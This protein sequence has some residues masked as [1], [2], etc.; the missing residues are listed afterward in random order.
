M[1]F[2]IIKY[3]VALI[4]SFSFILAQSSRMGTASS[5]QLQIAQGAQYLSGGG[6]AS[7][8][9]GMGAVYWNPAGLSK[10]E[11][12]FDAIFS[13]R[14]YI[15]DITNNYF[16]VGGNFGNLGKLALTV[17]TFNIGDIKETTVYQPDGTG[18][19]FTPQF[20]V[21][22]TTISKSLTDRTSVG[23]S[24]NWIS[25]SFGRVNANSVAFDLGVQYNKLMNI[26]N[27]NIG[28]VL[29]NFGKPM[30]YEGEGL[31]IWAEGTDTDR[32]N[33]YY[34]IDAASFD[35]PYVMDMSLSYMFMGI[36]CG[37]TF[38][39]NYYATDEIRLLAS[40]DI[41]GLG[42]VR[43]GYLQSFSPKNI[44]N[45]VG[46]WDDDHK[47]PFDGISFGGSLNLGSLISSNII[48]DYAYMPTE[49]FDDNQVFSLRFGF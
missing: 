21:V 40:Y 23:L 49:Y 16:G 22:G 37:A 41:L 26:Q 14:T 43:A 47:N 11:H 45:E 46:M 33:E 19:V 27:L 25:E 2:N 5:T 42:T 32:P 28:F 34:K 18:Q 9:E 15:A 44:D 48:L 1:K 4:I 24:A 7:N 17:R 31:G 30:T 13:Y 6:A 12:N 8:A 39:S 29:K 10:S 35:L 36:N 38:T 20:M 3:I